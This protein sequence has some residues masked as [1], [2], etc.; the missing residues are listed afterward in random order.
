[1]ERL[2]EKFSAAPRRVRLLK[3]LVE[4]TLAGESEQLSEY[5][6]GIDV[7][8]KL[9]SFDPRSDSMVRTDIMRLRQRLREYYAGDG[10]ADPILLD[11]PPRSYQVTIQFRDNSPVEEVKPEAPEGQAIATAAPAPGR[12]TAIYRRLIAVAAVAACVVGAALWMVRKQRLQTIRSVIVLPF[13]DFSSDHQSGYLADGLTDELTND[14]ANLSG[15]RVIARTT[16][17]EYRN[18]GVDIREVGRELNVDGSIE[19]SLDREGDHIRIRVQFNRNADGYHIWSRVYDVQFRDLISVQRDMARSIAD[20][21]QLTPSLGG[22]ASPDTRHD[23]APEAHEFYLRAYEAGNALSLDSMR[24]A[25]AL[26][27][28]AVD[29]DP[30]F[31]Q[32]WQLLA[33]VHWNLGV[34]GSW[35]EVSPQQVESEARRA[36]DLDGSLATAHATL[37]QLFWRQYHDWEK[38]EAEFRVALRDGPGMANVHQIYAGCLAERGRFEE[39]HREYRAAEELSPLYDAAF[40]AEAYVYW[41][42]GRMA[43][44]ERLYQFV[45]ARKPAFPVAV[46][47]MAGLRFGSKDCAGGESY[48]ARLKS[49]APGSKYTWE[50]DL[51]APVCRGALKDARR[52][53]EHSVGAVPNIELAGGYALIGDSDNAIRYLRRSVELGEVGI[54]GLKSSLYFTSLQSDPRFAAIERELGLRP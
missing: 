10:G 41:V 23:P 31:A 50:L 9:P 19:G 33:S 3:Y 29:R 20:D 1:M 36:L 54:T 22:T 42:E 48:E 5:A 2:A 15:L 53:L 39:S 28:S 47:G 12:R 24:R 43:D 14:L 16:A 51:A 46:A 6:I 11:L 34:L 8:D 37:G 25:A 4:R 21:L 18:K 26:A 32:A 44:A 40:T 17:F 35:K 38:A 49:S 30:R 7:F 45:L 27:Q 13:Q 52:F